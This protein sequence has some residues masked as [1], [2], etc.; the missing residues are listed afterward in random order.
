MPREE[1]AFRIVQA[2]PTRHWPAL[3]AAPFRRWA[4]DFAGA[5]LPGHALLP[6]PVEGHGVFVVEN[7]VAIAGKLGQV[8]GVDGVLDDDPA[9]QCKKVDL[10]L[11]CARVG[12]GGLL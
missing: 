12:H 1:R 11:R 8:S 7:L 10:G 2:S 5:L 6:G 9:V 4:S 3:N